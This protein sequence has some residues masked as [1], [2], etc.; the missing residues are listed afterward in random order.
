MDALLLLKASMLLAGTLLAERLLRRAPAVTRHRLWS[1]VF[2][3]VLALPLLAAV[4]PALYVPIPAAWETAA[5]VRAVDAIPL[6]DR[7]RGNADRADTTTIPRGISSSI[8]PPPSLQPD[9]A[10][11]DARAEAW[12]G[13][14]TLLLTGWGIGAAAAM[15]VLFV[16]LLRARRLARNA[17]DVDDPRWRN[18]ADA[19]GARLGLRHPV[20]LLLSTGVATPMA[21]G[22]WRAAIFLPASARTWSVERRDVVL[23]HEMAHLAERDP[24]RHLVARLAL[25]FY[26]F[27]PLAWI[28]ARQG[29]V[30]R[31]QA[32][33][34]AV[35]ALGT[36]RSVY[37]RVLLELAESMG[38]PAPALAALPMVQRS[39]LENRL[40]AILN[41][42]V[43]PVTRRLVLIPASGLA[44]LTLTLAA[45]QPG[46]PGARSV[47]AGVEP[48]VSASSSHMAAMTAPS[49]FEPTE[50]APTD[51]VPEPAARAETLRLTRSLV[52]SGQAVSATAAQSAVGRDSA[53]WW[54]STDRSSF[55]GTISSTDVGGRTVIYEQVGTRGD[56]RVIQK[57]F[58]D[59]RLCM[60]AED[61]GA[62][63]TAGLP[64]GWIGRARRVV[65][66]ARRGGLVQR[67]EI[68]PQAAGG[69][70]SWRIGGVQRPLDNAAQQW[71]DRMLAALDTTWEV[72]TLRGEV[73]SLRGQISSI[74]GQRSSFQGEISS[75]NG[76]I[77]SMRGRQSSIR[78]EESSMRGR[79]SSIQGHVSSLRGA[80][81]S[82]QG[83]ISS[84][85][86]GRYRADDSD[87]AR[88]ARH[89][90]EI[91]R[92]EQEIR[93]YGAG[94]RIAAVEREI[95]SL[96]ADRKVAA[97]ES[98]IRAFNLDGK[99]TAI[100]RRIAALDVEGKV[101][102]IERQIAALDADRRTRQLEQR[103]DDELKQLEATIAAIR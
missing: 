28:A 47:R 4:L 41:D 10:Q 97:I 85:N 73:S 42:D 38:P 40:M 75:L 26:W 78:G 12:P 57:T 62:R 96:D 71:R 36:R 92:I 79:I 81:S 103:Q 87:R 13:A 68:G 46:A 34:E 102:A 7:Q 59:L 101:A 88:I 60:V 58:G 37:A 69:V 64:S 76:E 32:C 33:D 20:R 22:V 5:P 25:A 31:E 17:D 53:C 90:A 21:G 2:A 89:E 98:E 84:L 61:V 44:L 48:A 18:A 80:I 9:G 100:E 77:S 66:E 49:S 14:T 19:I 8:E 65:L 91:A 56:S 63:D 86:A 23:A 11:P 99:V 30:A 93:D 35:L 29:A 72:A 45:A 3:A 55:N 15:S 1:V 24:L 16:S 39:L 27:H 54:D 82:E 74:H 52:R 50:A 43:R 6:N 67:M 51:A 95:A 83:A 70:T 94:A